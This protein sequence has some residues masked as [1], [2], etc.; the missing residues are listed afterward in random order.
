MPHAFPEGCPQ[1]PSYGQGHST[2]A[3]ACATIVKAWFD[4]TAPLSSI[5]GINISQPSEDGFSLVPY[6]GAD[7]DKLT[8][9]G[10]MN[11]LAANIGIGRNHAAVHW[12]YDYA[13]SLPLGEAVAISLLRDMASCWNEPFPGF[14]FTRFDGTRITGVGKNS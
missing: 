4:D 7:R 6:S 1:Q 8:I 11:K 14:S 5:A 2:V 13:D 9:G 3:G 12:R 10:E